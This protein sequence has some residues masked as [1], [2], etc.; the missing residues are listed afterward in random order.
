MISEGSMIHETFYGEYLKN[1]LAGHHRKCRGM[2]QE[3]IDEGIGIKELYTDLFQRSMYEVGELWENNRITVAREHLATS[4]TDSLLNLAYPSLFSTARTGKRA[5]VSCSVNEYHQ[6]GAK[7]VADIF[8]LH[9]WDGHFLGANAPAEDMARFIHEV[10]PDVV[11]LSL[12]LLSNMDKLKHHIDVIRADFPQMDLLVG[13]QAF[14]WGGL[15]V[16]G[17]YGRTQYIPSLERLEATLAE[18]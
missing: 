7:M 11:G 5:V 15:E 10:N 17:S 6:I 1:L 3:L 16:I 12:S 13:G 14:R 4:I 9:G 18:A 2:V 8:E